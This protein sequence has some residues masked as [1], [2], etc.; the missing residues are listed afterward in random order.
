MR[1]LAL[2]LS[3]VAFPATAHE[4]WIEPWAYEVPADGTVQADIVNGEAF[5]GTRLAYIPQRFAHFVTFFDG[6][7]TPVAGRVGDQP[8]L[9]QAPL[10][11]G[12]HVVAYQAR[13]ST[14]NYENWEK[15]QRFVEH[16]DFGDV[17]SRHRELGHPEEDF[18]EVY[19]R[20]SK[21]LIGVGSAEG[22]DLRTGLTTELVALDNPYTDDVSGGLRL[23]LFYNQDVR[24]DTQVEI[25]EKA[26]DGSVT[27][28]FYRTDADGI[29]TIPVKPGHAYQADAVVLREPEAQ[30]ARDTGAVWETLWANLT[31]A[32]PE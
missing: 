7:P 10:G 12:L 11:D 29:A 6:A 3:L 24:A 13:N 31:W 16:K 26:P 28:S 23:Q 4:F 9:T 15:F 30:L 8:A 14:V 21:S 27:Q 22:S 19:S 25:F 20:Y 17:L 5:E 18:F 1:S 32:V 2:V